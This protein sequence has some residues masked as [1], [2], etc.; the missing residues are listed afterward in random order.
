MVMNMKPVVLCILDGVGI[1]EEVH[2]NAF[3]MANKPNFDYLWNNYP[4]SLLDASG[5]EVGLPKGQ[6][7]NSEVGHMNIGAGRVV[8]QPLQLITKHINDG[9]FFKNEELLN[10]I[11][12]V[13]K[14]N[15][16]MHI[17]GLVSDGGIHSTMS[18]LFAC[19]DMCKKEGIK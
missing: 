14:N 9:T 13:K 1:R 5:E 2:G 17:F 4:H 18:H 19:I 10:V 6:M 8:F 11:N 12:H 3:K 15:S 16:K 7:G